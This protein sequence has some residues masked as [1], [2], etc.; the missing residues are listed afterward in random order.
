MRRAHA[1]HTTAQDY[2]GLAA[3]D[4]PRIERIRVDVAASTVTTSNPSVTAGIG[5]WCTT[6][7]V[8]RPSKHVAR[9][10][11]LSPDAVDH[12]ADART[13]SVNQE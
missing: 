11:M 1:G 10:V 8:S 4:W 12:H 3:H 7:L 9:V 2:Y 13:L 5:V 6:V